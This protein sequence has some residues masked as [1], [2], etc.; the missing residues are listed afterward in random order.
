MQASTILSPKMLRSPVKERT[1]LQ[2]D[3]HIAQVQALGQVLQL[4]EST[5]F[6]TV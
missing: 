5:L 2:G 4:W 1:C 3:A 6:G